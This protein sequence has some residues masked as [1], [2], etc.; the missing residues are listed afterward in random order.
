[1]DAVTKGLTKLDDNLYIDR[2]TGDIFMIHGNWLKTPIGSIAGTELFDMFDD[3]YGTQDGIKT[4][5]AIAKI[6]SK[7]FNK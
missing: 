2:D 3:S 6:L 1:M 4:R 5:K 7:S